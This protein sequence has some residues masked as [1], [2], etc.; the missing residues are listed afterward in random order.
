MGRKYNWLTQNNFN[1]CKSRPTVKVTFE[2]YRHDP[3]NINTLS[4]NV[5]TSIIE[6]RAGIIWVATQNGLNSFDQKTG[7]FKRYLHDPE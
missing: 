4:S 6:D 5:V 3:A 2:D 7:I 1:G